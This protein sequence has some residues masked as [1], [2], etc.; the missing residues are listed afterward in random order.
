MVSGRFVSED[1]SLICLKKMYVW[2][3]ECVCL[4]VCLIC[5]QEVE[6]LTEEQICK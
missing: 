3:C 4:S 5:C 2:F 1:F 6:R